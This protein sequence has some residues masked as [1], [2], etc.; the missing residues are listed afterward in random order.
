LFAGTG[1]ENVVSNYK[2]FPWTIGWIPSYRIEAQIYGKYILANKPDAKIGVLFQNDDLGKVYIQGLKDGLGDQ[3]AK[4]VVKEVSYEVTDPTI[5]SQ[6]VTLQSSGADVLLS[7]ATPKFAAQMIRKIYDLGWKPLHCMSYV[8]SSV[9]AVLK[10]AGPERAI[11]MITASFLKGST[12]PTWTSD[13]GMKEWRDFMAKYMPDADATDNNYVVSYAVAQTAE[14]VLKQ[15][16]GDFSRENIMRQATNLHDVHIA[17]LLPGISVNTS[18]TNYHPV[19]QMQLAK[20]NGRNWELF[21]AVIEG[22]SP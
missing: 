22:P 16:D 3:Y 5:D 15:C 11:G 8:S 2:E 9:G 4:L 18:P 21:G 1:A 12:D 7:A 6:A 17:I 14:R 20:F 10:P 19:R 13:A